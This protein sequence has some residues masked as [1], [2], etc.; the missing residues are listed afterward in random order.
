MK[1]KKNLYQLIFQ[2]TTV[3]LRESRN[4]LHVQNF[5]PIKVQISAYSKT[6]SINQT[7]AERM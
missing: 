5:Q 4:Y 7:N 3:M 6:I 1:K 2:L